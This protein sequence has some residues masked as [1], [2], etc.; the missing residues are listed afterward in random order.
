MA[1][2]TPDGQPLLSP[3]ARRWWAVALVVFVLLLLGPRLAGAGC[4]RLL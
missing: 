4:N 2:R 1:L 3:R